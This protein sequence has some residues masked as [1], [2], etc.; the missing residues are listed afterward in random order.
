[1]VRKFASELNA[2]IAID[3]MLLSPLLALVPS[4]VIGVNVLL[5]IRNCV[6]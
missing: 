6:V 5:G 2:I 1:M 3:S 4:F